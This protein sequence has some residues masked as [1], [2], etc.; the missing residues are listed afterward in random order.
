M[1]RKY[2]LIIKEISSWISYLITALFLAALLQSQ[3]FAINEVS[4][5][6]M[7]NTLIEGQKLIVEKISYV[8]QK[9]K[10]GDIIVFLEKEETDGFLKRLKIYTN[11]IMLK[12]KG[13]ERADR[14]IKRVIAV[15]GDEIRIKNEEV[16]V[17]G[18]LLKEPYLK[19][20]GLDDIEEIVPEGCV[21][22][23]GDNRLVSNDSRDFGPVKI[24]QIEGKAFYR[25]LP[26]DKI[27]KL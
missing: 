24:K 19:S 13:K 18:E 27:G 12:I 2:K 17:N 25:L 4:L 23:M 5:S 16:Y 9:P 1:K 11:D 7:E 21:Y 26:I 10:Q 3:V 6:S 20:L 8:I 14:L 22:V 15:G